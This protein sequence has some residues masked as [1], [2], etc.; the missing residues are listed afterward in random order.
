M[1]DN[2]GTLER[3]LR[4]LAEALEPLGEEIGPA[5]INEL[6]LGMPAAWQ[7]QLNSSFQAVR[8]AAQ[9]LPG[10]LDQL[11]QAITSGNTG[12]IIAK[13]VLLGQKI[14]EIT[15]SVAATASQLIQLA[16]ADGTLNPAQ[17]ANVQ[18]FADRFFPRLAETLIIRL[19][20]TKLPQLAATLNLLGI[21][22]KTRQTGDPADL[23]AP[24]Y[25]R[26]ELRLDRIARIFKEPA[27]YARDLVDFGAPGFDG[28]KLL[29]RVKQFLEG[30]GFPAHLI[31][32]GPQP[33][34]LEA[35][36]VGLQ[37]NQAFTPP[38]LGFE[39]RFPGNQTFERTFALPGP[40]SF[41]T[42]F[43]GTFSAGVQGVIEAPAS[44][45]LQP[46]S[47]SLSFKV[48]NL[49]VAHRQGEVLLLVGLPGGTRLEAGRI[50]LGLAIEAEW[51]SGSGNARARPIATFSVEDGRF[52]L[53]LRG[54]DGFL[55]EV[56]PFEA[57]EAVFSLTGEYDPETGLRF[58][59][60]G[61]VEIA[62]AAH[63]EIGPIT[64]DRLYFAARLG[65]P[66]PLALELSSA[67][68]LHLGPLAASVDRIGAVASFDFPGDGRGNLGPVQFD[69]GFKPPNG[70]GLSIDAGAVSG[71]GYLYF[72]FENEEYAGALEISVLNVVTVKA[73][74][75]IT[76][77]LPDG[78]KGFSLL[79][80][81]TAEFGTG[82]QLGFGFTL[83]GVGGL[84]GLNRTMRLE[85]IAQGI[86]TGGL[87]SVMF[88]QNVVENAPRIIS[89]LKTYFP[90]ERDRFLIGPM[91]KIGWGT[92]PLI[93]LA[94]GV[95]IEIP[96]GNIAILGVLKVALPTEDAP[97][98]LLQVQFI[99]AIEPTKKRLWFFASLYGSRVV[100]LTLEGDMG[101]LMAFGDDAN[102]VLSVGGF[103]PSFTPPPLPFPSPRRIAISILDL[104]WARIR[105]E[106]YF[107]VTSNTV[108]FGSRTE[109]FFGFDVANIS[110]HMQFDALFQFSPFY[111]IVEISASV[112]LKVFG[113]GL[114]SVRLRFA[115]EGTS[116]WR[117]RGEAGISIL[118][119]EISV[120]FDVTW[121]E[122]ADTELPPV[123]VLPLLQAEFEKN[124][125]WRAELPAANQLSVS[126]R[127][128]GNGDSPELVLHP[129][130]FLRV[131]QRGVPLGIQ[132][133]KV[134][135][136]RAADGTRF[137]VA[138][139]GGTGFAR[140][141]DARERFAIAQYQEMSDADKLSR[142]A[143]QPENGGLELSVT[144]QQLGASRAARRTVRYELEIIDTPKVRFRVRIF[145]AWVTGLFSHWL[146][147]NAVARSPISKGT[148]AKLQP[149]SEAEKVIVHE[150]AFVVAFSRD[151]RAFDG[152]A[153]F[154]SEAE[155]RS[156]MN[157]RI[158][159][160]PGLAEELHV[161]P[162][163]ESQ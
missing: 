87:D 98:V 93:S 158:R 152:T 146:R 139:V 140:K 78:S 40:W 27:S 29:P 151:N 3:V 56:I 57:V 159:A 92:P 54:G 61:G 4:R 111:F 154:Q 37:A 116:P 52:R 74:G 17:K 83:L 99:G 120:D 107:A 23:T 121:G 82:I 123:D 141:A 62:F 31:P 18:Q 48:T 114:F 81:L 73:I 127:P 39:L 70:V 12:E 64:I 157:H 1:S 55:S 130:G 89:D 51:D 9:A 122:R 118:F 129:I 45:T 90:P 36:F 88:P 84:L 143:F 137:S 134:G 97:L 113:A 72:D 21:A 24:P 58:E 41:Q 161:I 147:G 32:A 104:D 26:R 142:P 163:H 28:S 50:A 20:E 13:G 53:D 103:H 95:V 63:L 10:A 6:G 59:G 136:R 144:G 5:L 135:S 79:I 109:L 148:Q 11:G 138:P 101:L 108:Q 86:R 8:S 15:L 30:L 160:Q 42:K 43:E 7:T 16:Q 38:A 35:F 67:I 47:G 155:A 66:M 117:A 100:F 112:S 156:F 132:V 153:V 49:L 75:L 76:T 77:R 128:L 46:P 124:E 19:L 71:G 162:A 105:V 80:I 102:F 60:S 150:E 69:L 131:A 126:L 115:L 110:G 34:I 133:D 91:A 2:A 85:V 94:L 44:V 96:P 106:A 33:P 14:A 25:P 68:R 119:F 65:S 149:F 22:E 125:N 145:A